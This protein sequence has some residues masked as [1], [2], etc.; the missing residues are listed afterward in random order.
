MDWWEW[1]VGAVLFA[2]Y[3]VCLFTV[4]RLTFEKELL[5]FFELTG[6]GQRNCS[7]QQ[8]IGGYIAFRLADARP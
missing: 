1:I 7:T 8:L 4:C 5:G 6:G 3:I 2:F